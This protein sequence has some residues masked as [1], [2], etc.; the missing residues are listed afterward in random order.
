MTACGVYSPAQTASRQIAAV[1]GSQ[2]ERAGNLPTAKAGGPWPQMSAVFRAHTVS[3]PP[4]DLPLNTRP[5]PCDP[6][7]HRQSRC[8]GKQA[9]H[10]RR[11]STPLFRTAWSPLHNRAGLIGSTWREP[12]RIHHS[13][14]EDRDHGALYQPSTMTQGMAALLQPL[15]DIAYGDLVNLRQAGRPV[16]QIDQFAAGAVSLATPLFH[17]HAQR[18]DFQRPSIFLLQGAVAPCCHLACRAMGKDV[19]VPLARR[20]LTRRR[21]FQSALAQPVDSASNASQCERRG[22]RCRPPD[23]TR[24][25]WRAVLGPLPIATTGRACRVEP[26]LARRHQRC[27]RCTYHGNG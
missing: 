24:D 12:V 10:V 26:L 20:A 8:S 15:V 6:L 3:R 2:A 23:S 27:G 25:G 14:Q 9:C 4:P 18:T 5:L 19:I 7:R 13:R 16:N 1:G 21:R 11:W 22:A 17:Q